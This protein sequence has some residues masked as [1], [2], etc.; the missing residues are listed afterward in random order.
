MMNVWR[1]YDRL[2]K[3]AW[4]PYQQR[5][6]RWVGEPG[7]RWIYNSL[8]DAFWLPKPELKEDGGY[9]IDKEWHYKRMG[10]K[11]TIGEDP[12]GGKDDAGE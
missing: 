1:L 12:E 10:Y 2:E 3:E 6:N 5:F 8:F 4:D 9:W 7:N 11:P